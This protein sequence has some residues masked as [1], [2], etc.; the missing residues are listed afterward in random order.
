[1]NP[2]DPASTSSVPP[3]SQGG[4]PRTHPAPDYDNEVS[5]L[6]GPRS[7]VRELMI[8]IRVMRDFLRGFR[9]LHFVGPCVTVFGSAR[10]APGTPHYELA[11]RLGGEIVRLGFTVMT[12]GGP[13][14]MEAAN[15]GAREAGGR[16]VGCNIELPFE[17]R[18]NPYLDRCVTMHYFFVRKTLLVKYSYAFVVLP[19]GAGTLDELFEALTLVQTGKLQRFPIIVMGLE[20]WREVLEFIQKMAREGTI[21]PG[22]LELIHATDSVEEAIRHLRE[23]AIGPFGLKP[24]Q[25]PSKWLG[26]LALGTPA[27]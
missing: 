1:M 2:V 25:R 20:Y 15:R 9:A 17:Q 11:R 26:E 18:P 6:E 3:P 4:P 19:G 10:T 12:G 21:S 16:S 5:F 22:D 23:K 14:I 24:A 13:G 7:R 8:L 27:R